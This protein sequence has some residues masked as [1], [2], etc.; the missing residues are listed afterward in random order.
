MLKYIAWRILMMIPTLFAISIVSFLIIQLPPGDFLTSYL[1]QLTSMGETVSEEVIEALRA[2]YGLGSPVYVQYWTW[3]TGIITQGD[4]GMS[5]LWGRPVSELLWERVSLT[6]MV[7][8]SSVLFIWVVA[9][10]IGIYSAVRQY[11]IGDYI[12]TFLGFLGLATPPF[13]LAL[14]ALWIVFV[15]TGSVLVGLFSPEYID[16]SWSFGKA[17]DLLA[18]LW[19]PMVILGTAGTAGTIRVIRAQMLDELHKPYVVTARAKGV[20]ELK[21]LFKYPVR[22]ALNPFFSTLGWLLPR[23][24]AGEILVSIVLNLPTTGPLL[25]GALTNQDMYLAGSFMLILSTLTVIGTLIS[26]ILL[27]WVDPR[28]RYS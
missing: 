18:H 14:I 13:M 6:V 25:L 12:F 23:L 15:S 2:R 3:M 26:D 5:L 7:S 17:L 20:S 24:I 22:I 21:L 16:A 4:F 28:I 8:A 10:P 11:S 9:I 19:I 1:A 27:A